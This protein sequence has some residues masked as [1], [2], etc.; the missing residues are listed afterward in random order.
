M[1]S[2]TERI[3]MATEAVHM[4]GKADTMII[5]DDGSRGLLVDGGKGVQREIDGEIERVAVLDI[6][7]E[8]WDIPFDIRGYNVETTDTRELDEEF[9]LLMRN[10]FKYW[11]D[12]AVERFKRS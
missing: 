9:F 2:E 12:M 11:L 3:E 8:M 6:S 1:F 4:I 5:Y 10:A 7:K